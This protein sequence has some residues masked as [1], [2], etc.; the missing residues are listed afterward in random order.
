MEINDSY[1]LPTAFDVNV[2]MG[3]RSSI[4]YKVE[5]DIESKMMQISIS[6]QDGF[7]TDAEVE[8]GRDFIVKSIQDGSLHLPTFIPLCD[9]EGIEQWDGIREAM[10]E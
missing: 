6:S 9:V 1:A 3:D 5:F 7:F 2:G 10:E 4:T 8:Q